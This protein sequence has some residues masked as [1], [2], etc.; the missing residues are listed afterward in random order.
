MDA[1]SGTT[2]AHVIPDPIPMGIPSFIQMESQKASDAAQEGFVDGKD[3]GKGKKGKKGEFEDLLP[4]WMYAMGETYAEQDKMNGGSGV[5]GKYLQQLAG[6]QVLQ[7]S[8]AKLISSAS[9]FGGLADY[10][11][12]HPEFK[13]ELNGVGSE[14]TALY[15]VFV[16]WNATHPH[17]DSNAAAM[18]ANEFS[19]MQQT[20]NMI[21]QHADLTQSSAK[22]IQNSGADV[23]SDEAQIEEEVGQIAGG[24]LHGL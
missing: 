11:T 6:V 21:T 7:Q 12:H 14:A 9:D 20:G 24:F 16:N 1:T 18:Q 2:P 22:R 17:D 23:T 8:F 19:Y 15:N 4:K 13:T 10:I 3:D 5:I